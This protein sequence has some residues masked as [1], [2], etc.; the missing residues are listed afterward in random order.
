MKT[1]AETAREEA[2]REEGIARRD[3][4]WQNRGNRP[5][6]KLTLR[7]AIGFVRIERLDHNPALY[8]TSITSQS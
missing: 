7:A 2:A 4:L 5:P 8:M 3:P 6:G 1:R